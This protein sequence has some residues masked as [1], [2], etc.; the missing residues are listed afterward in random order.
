VSLSEKSLFQQMEEL[1]AAVTADLSLMDAEL[2][3]QAAGAAEVA[4]PVAEP[5][6]ERA[7]GPLAD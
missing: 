1:L 7:T 2:R 4:E 6:A 5:A 3:P